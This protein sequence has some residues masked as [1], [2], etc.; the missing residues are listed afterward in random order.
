MNLEFKLGTEKEIDIILEMMRQFNLIDNYPFD[1][2]VT[3][4]NLIEFIGNK[5]FG[6]I[7]LIV[8]SNDIIGYVVL[9][10][11]FSF[12]YKGKDAFIDELFI[13]ESY[14][15]KGI[16]S[17]TIKFV[18]GQA[19]TLGINTI[20]LEVE[21]HNVKGNELYYRFG[22]KGNDRRLLTKQL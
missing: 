4:Q 2:S 5:N 14:I 22:F 6:R 10:F 12:E 16:G 11:G 20:H 18:S 7:W 19:K 8:C 21:T 15:G 13:E 17:E 3:K 1:E 9:S